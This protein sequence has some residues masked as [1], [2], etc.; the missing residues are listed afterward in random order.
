[1]APGS[2]CARRFGS[3]MDSRLGFIVKG[4]D[5]VGHWGGVI[6]YHRHDEKGLKWEPGGVMSGAGSGGPE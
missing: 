6:V 5:R 4:G 3:R 1:M 2:G